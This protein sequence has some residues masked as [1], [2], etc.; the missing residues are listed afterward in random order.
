MRAL[1]DFFATSSEGRTLQEFLAALEHKHF[2]IKRNDPTFKD[3][4]EH[5]YKC[6]LLFNAPPSIFEQVLKNEVYYDDKNLLAAKPREVQKW[7]RKYD[8]GAISAW[9]K[10]QYVRVLPSRSLTNN[11]FRISGMYILSGLPGGPPLPTVGNWSDL[12]YLPDKPS[13]VGHLA[14]LTIRWRKAG[15]IMCGYDFKFTDLTINQSFNTFND[16]TA[17]TLSLSAD[18]Y[19]TSVKC[20]YGDR[21][22]IYSNGGEAGT[23]SVLHGL[24]I[25]TSNPSKMLSVGEFYSQDRRISWSL[26]C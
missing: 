18:E 13:S 10:H 14:N 5:L 26:V 16:F 12:Y 1:R 3:F 17:H 15:V 22:Y 20:S 21:Y 19:I 24:E 7:L 25:Q 23:S 9:S 2:I 6:Y 8:D 4:Y 11:R